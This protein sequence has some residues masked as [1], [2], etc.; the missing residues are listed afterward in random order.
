MGFKNIV[1]TLIAIL[2]I[3]STIFLVFY[4]NKIKLADLEQKIKSVESELQTA[5]Q[6]DFI[7]T[8]KNLQCIVFKYVQNESGE[9]IYTLFEGKL[10]SR[11]GK[12]T[13]TMYGKTPRDVLPYESALLI[14]EELKKAFSGVTC[15]YELELDGYVYFD[16]LSPVIEDGKVI[17]VIGS[18]IDI[19]EN[20]KIQNQVRLLEFYDSLTN[21]PNRTLFKDRLDL[22]IPHAKRNG[23]LLSIMLIDLD[24]FKTVNDSLGHDSGDSLLKEVALRLKNIIREDDTLARLGGDEFAFIITDID[25]ENEIVSVAEKT[26]AAFKDPFFINSSELY[27]TASIGIS[28]FPNDGQDAETLI[29][30]ADM[31][32][33]RSK[34]SGK[35]SYNF[36]TTSMNQ[37]VLVKLNM[38]NSLR[39]A[40]EKEEL[41]LHYQ[42]QVDIHTGKLVGCEALIRWNNP[43][44]GMVSPGDFIPLAE[45][46]GLITPIGEWVLRAA[47]YQLKAWHDAGH[48]YLRMAVNISA[49]QFEKQNLV[50]VLDSVL[51]ETAVNPSFLELEITENSIMKNTERTIEILKQIKDRKVR[52]SIDDFGTGFSSL[53]YL[54]QFSADALK[55]DQSFV[56]N[57][58]TSEGSLAIINAIIT[59]AH[60]LKLS[61]IA[62]GVETEDQ[63]ALLK[64]RACDEIQGYLISRPMPAQNFQKLL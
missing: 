55:I 17:E 14:E 13:D 33:Y 21:L 31:A 53:S 24:R 4:I 41:I 25:H 19:T 44:I 61:V 52:I 46:T 22:A 43:F 34:D 47:C 20:K 45:E 50:Q 1:H 59:M 26:L 54:Q 7:R 27:A 58:E 12:N 2:T 36:F 40:I 62:E 38:E 23:Q 3:S 49:Q 16:T 32:M 15:S 64:S 28:T 18:S 39:K 48:S 11:Q 10:S 57:A 60:S 51:T 35:N 63:L 42:P 9:F 37:R 56:R 29:K 5:L 6:N 30:N 8:I